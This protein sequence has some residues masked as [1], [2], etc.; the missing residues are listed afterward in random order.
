MELDGAQNIIE[1]VE[2]DHI[3]PKPIRPYLSHAI[4]GEAPNEEVTDN[5]QVVYK[6]KPLHKK[7]TKRR[8]KIEEVHLLRNKYKKPL[9]QWI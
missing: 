9:G 5:F 2:T 4:S 6:T 3:V 1:R 7:Q 8:P